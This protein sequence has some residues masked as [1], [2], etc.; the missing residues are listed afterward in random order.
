MAWQER[1]QM[2]T[3]ITDAQIRAL[4]GEAIAH[5]DY[6]QADLCDRARASDTIDQ[7]GHAIAYA[8]WSQS[9]AREACAAVVAAAA[10][11]NT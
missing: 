2:T 3:T 7:D 5:G 8:D 10:A 6:A 9:E 1:D 4:R 11:A